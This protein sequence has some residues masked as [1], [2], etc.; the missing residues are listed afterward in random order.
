MG[1][2][3]S[4]N[5]DSVTAPAIP[6]GWTVDSPL[7][8]ATTL[9]PSSAPN[10]LVF[11]A[12]SGNG[13]IYFATWGTQ[14][15]ASG[16]V[17]VSATIRF[18]NGTASTEQDVMVFARG[19]QA[20]TAWNTVSLYV[21]T[22][23]MGSSPNGLLLQKRIAAATTTIGASVG[24]SALA[25]GTNYRITL[26][27]QGTTITGTCQRLSD[28]FW[29]N[30]GGT[31]QSSPA[32]ALVATDS[33][34]TG[35]GYAGAAVYLADT[36]GG[37]VGL[38][39]WLLENFLSPPPP[40]PARNEIATSTTSGRTVYA[41]V[42]NNAAQLWNTGTQA[43]EV[44]A[45]GNW[46]SYALD[47]V[48][49]DSCGFYGASFPSA[50]TAPGRYSV[51]IRTQAG[52]SPAV[53]DQALAGGSVVWGGSAET[54]V[55]GNSSGQVQHDLTQAVP[56]SNTGQT[57]GDAFNAARAQGFGKWALSGTSLTLYAADGTTVV[58]TFVLD[59]ATAP[60]SRT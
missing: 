26:K 51:D 19:S 5:W 58:R 3:K 34:I 12:A 47:L 39:D 29:L 42:R 18:A 14:D 55:L 60:T 57:V 44:F 53:A 9:A 50:I 32:T 28:S 35:Q 13:G 1:I 41:L 52:S 16:E 40:M 7:A 17:Q 22:L 20:A 2:I 4:E 38:D 15:G 25:N 23:G 45:S 21:L 54:F 49:Q 30:S 10:S 31:F 37:N 48:E 43:F 27:C 6:G 56:S 11:P 46:A 24:G 33:S 59:S 36:T 8:T